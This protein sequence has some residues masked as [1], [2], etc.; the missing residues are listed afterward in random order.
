MPRREKRYVDSPPLSSSLSSCYV[1]SDV[2]EDDIPQKANVSWVNEDVR[3]SFSTYSEFSSALECYKSLSHPYYRTSFDIQPCNEDDVVC[4]APLDESKCY[5]YVYYCTFSKLGVRLPFT[6]FQCEILR[7]LNVAPS[8]LHP[9][10]WAFLRSFEILSRGLNIPASAYSFFSFFNAKKSK[11]NS[12][13]YMSNHLHH[14]LIR[15]Y[16]SSWR[17]YKSDFIRVCP[18]PSRSEGWYSESQEPRFPFFWTKKPITKF[19]VGDLPHSPEDARAVNVLRDF[20]SLET[21][22]LLCREDDENELSLYLRNT[23]FTFLIVTL[24]YLNDICT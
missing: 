4:D 16:T 17:N 20:G 5:T 15:S 19:D 12:W 10:C 3:S 2:E 9:N 6:D 11:P 23:P 18:S 1:E 14:T 22:E 7:T 24:M 13:L 8:Q 21:N